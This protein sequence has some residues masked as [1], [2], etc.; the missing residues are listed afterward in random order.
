MNP[1]KRLGLGLVLLVAVLVAVSF[2]LP[3][4]ISVARS[5]VIN[6]PEADVFPYLND[7]RKFNEWS[8]WAARDP[9]TV[10]TFEGPP[11]G[12]GARMTWRSD[13]PEVGAGS[14]EIIESEPNKYLKV[15]LSFEGEGG[16]EADFTLDPSGAGTKVTWG[17]SSDVGNNPM[18][19][20]MGLMF[21][22]WI[23]AD[24]EAG[25]ARLEQRIAQA[26]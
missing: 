17:F 11:Q 8:P 14:Q 26:R 24:Y 19:R 18:M 23:G 4:N 22:R 6:A 7:Y 2:A 3:Q 1:I 16:G 21:D 5:R 9:K 10:Y 13:N 20:W 15:A 25:L 12:V